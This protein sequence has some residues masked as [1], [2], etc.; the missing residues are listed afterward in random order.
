MALLVNG[1]TAITVCVDGRRVINPVLVMDMESNLVVVCKPDG[2]RETLYGQL[3][4]LVDLHQC[5]A[6]EKQNLV[7][8]PVGGEYP[9]IVPKYSLFVN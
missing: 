9:L 3:S 2:G 6:L 8:S 4:W 7:I 1:S 5:Q